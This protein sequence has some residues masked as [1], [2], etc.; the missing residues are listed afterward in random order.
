M[1]N[2]IYKYAMKYRGF[3]IGCQPIQNLIEAQEDPTGKYYN[4]LLYSEPLTP[5]QIQS[6]QLIDMQPQPEIKEILINLYKALNRDFLRD[7]DKY[8]R[9]ETGK[10]LIILIRSYAEKTK[11][12]PQPDF[13]EYLEDLKTNNSIS[14][15]SDYYEIIDYMQ[16]ETSA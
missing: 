13:I 4:I 3:S 12:D 11:T 16:Q 7:L 15:M 10:P 8:A 9:T 5:E 1:K 6:Y 2:N 14:S